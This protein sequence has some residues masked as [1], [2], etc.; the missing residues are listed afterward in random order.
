MLKVIKNDLNMKKKGLLIGPF[1]ILVSLILFN[2][3]FI[4]GAYAVIYTVITVCGLAVNRDRIR[5]LRTLPVNVDDA[6]GSIYADGLILWGITFFIGLIIDHIRFIGGLILLPIPIN[7][8]YMPAMGG[9]EIALGAISFLMTAFGMAAIIPLGIGFMSGRRT[10]WVALI[11]ALLLSL[12]AVPVA[13]MSF[14]YAGKLLEHLPVCLFICI[15]ALGLLF[16]SY[17]LSL[18]Y[19]KKIN[20]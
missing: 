3:G 4:V 2:I 15:A 12:A 18:S 20:W 9:L 13:W 17:K 14:Y 19:Y 8:I 6:V 11:L 5:M 1:Y 10:G 7:M 16:A